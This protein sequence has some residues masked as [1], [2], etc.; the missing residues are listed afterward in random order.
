MTTFDPHH[1]WPRRLFL[2]KPFVPKPLHVLFFGPWTSL[3]CPTPLYRTP[4]PKT[5]LCG[6][7]RCVV[8][9]VLVVSLGCVALCCVVLW[10]CVLWCGVSVLCV[11]KIFV[12]ASKIWAAGHPLLR[13]T[14]PTLRDPTLRAPSHPT[15]FRA[16]L[17]LGLASTLHFWRCWCCCGCGCCGCCWFGS[18]DNR[19]PDHRTLDP[20]SAGPA[21]PPSA[22]PPKISRFFFSSPVTIFAL[23]SSLGGPF[24]EFWC[25]F[26]GGT[27]K[28]ARLGCRVKPRR[29]RGHPLHTTTRELQTCT[30]SP[31][32]SNT[33]K[34]P[35]KDTQERKKERTLWQ[36]RE[37]SAK[38]WASH[39]SGPSPSA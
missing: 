33:T 36:E 24:V 7:H 34:I 16:T 29:L 3:R 23:S 17:L 27:L 21:P 22:G 30:T 13:R 2:I 14:M 38:F 5:H 9:C 26:E 8:W 25:V 19:P 11:I 6:T 4:H 12:G 15:P 37:K 10:W 39:P 1:F 20:P 18:L 35:R 28:C 31:R 32:A